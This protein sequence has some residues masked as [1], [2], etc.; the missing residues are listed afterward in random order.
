MAIFLVLYKRRSLEVPGGTATGEQLGPVMDPA[1]VP[2]Q[3]GVVYTPVSR[4]STSDRSQRD[5]EALD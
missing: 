1:L 5:V 2:N 4:R 3:L